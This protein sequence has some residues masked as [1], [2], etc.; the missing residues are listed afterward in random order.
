M[1][2]GSPTPAPRTVRVRLVSGPLDYLRLA[3]RVLFWGLV[4]FVAFSAFETDSFTD[5]GHVVYLDADFEEVA[6][7][8]IGADDSVVGLVDLSGTIASFADSDVLAGTGSV[9]TPDVVRDAL[10]V[11]RAEGGL[12]GLVI[13]FETPGG[14]V[15]AA[16]EIRNTLATFKAREEIPL[17][18]YSSFVLASGGYYAACAADKVFAA[19]NAEVGSIGVII[20]LLN[21][22]KLATDTLGVNMKVY[23]SGE[24]KDMGNPFREPTPAE[25]TLLARDVRES[26]EAFV[27]E[28]SQ[29][30]KIPVSVVREKLGTG[31][32]WSGR[33]AKELGLVDE[34]LYPE[35]LAARLKT[36]I[37]SKGEVF[38]AAYQP[39]KG[40]WHTLETGMSA[41]LS[42]AMPKLPLPV[43]RKGFHTPRLYYLLQR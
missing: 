6:W 43:A 29:S 11:M 33:R 25:E 18:F 35:E 8:D 24:F 12:S 40:L 27:A 9:V 20:E 26:M 41:V 7:E 22:R 4:L 23:K 14:E 16:D 5:K 42:A 21:F 30:R 17:Y 32:V 2:P 37:D 10:S 28:V 13:R 15:A 31:E 34:V 39:P 1:I 19:K 38:Y 36:E 3:L